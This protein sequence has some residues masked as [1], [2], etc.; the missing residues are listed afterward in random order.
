MESGHARYGKRFL[1]VLGG[2]R[3]GVVGCGA[4][5]IIRKKGRLLKPDE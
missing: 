4:V 3:W 2:V 1:A 5:L